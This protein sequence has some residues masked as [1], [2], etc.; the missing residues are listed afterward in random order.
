MATLHSTVLWPTLTGRPRQR[1]L[2]LAAYTRIRQT[3]RSTAS[4]TPCTGLW[5]THLLSQGLYIISPRPS[6]SSLAISLSILPSSKAF[7]GH[8]IVLSTIPRS[9]S[10]AR[11]SCLHSPVCTHLSLSLS[12]HSLSHCFPTSTLTVPRNLLLPTS[13]AIAMIQ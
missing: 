4:A 1:E 5:F 6:L 7:P 8:H 9:L 10:M 11:L 3:P 13:P 2:S 12:T